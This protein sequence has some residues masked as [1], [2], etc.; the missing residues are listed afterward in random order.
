MKG[1]RIG[2]ALAI[3]ALLAFSIGSAG[4]ALAAAPGPEAG[5]QGD[6]PAKVA[7]GDGAVVSVILDF[8]PGAGV[9]EH[10]H[11]GPLVVTV[12]SGA[13][14]LNDEMGDMVFKAGESFTEMPGHKHSAF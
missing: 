1:L 4:S 5:A 2:R 13:L 8:A 14:T 9:P 7:A 3:L 10:T 6:M 12:L 11:G